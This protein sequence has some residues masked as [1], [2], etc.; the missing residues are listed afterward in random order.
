[1]TAFVIYIVVAF[2]LAGV[3]AYKYGRIDPDERDDIWDELITPVVLFIIFWPVVLPLALTGAAIFFPLHW[4][5]R[6]GERSRE[7][8]SK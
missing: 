4:I 6:L 8:D 3:V 2:V 7:K 5:Y 1:M